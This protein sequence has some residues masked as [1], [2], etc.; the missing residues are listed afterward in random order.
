MM[1]MK[2]LVAMLL[3]VAVVP[4]LASAQSF[5]FGLRKA[6]KPDTVLLVYAGT[7]LAVPGDAPLSAQSV[8]IRNDSVAE[9]HDGYID[10]DSI[11]AGEAQVKVI[12][13]RDHFVMPGMFDAHVHLST[14]T[15]SFQI[16][17]PGINSHPAV[18]DASV[19]AL[20]N[21]RLNL[22]A[23]FTALRDLGS[24]PH[25]VFAVR[26]AINAGHFIGPTIIAS[27]AS[28]SVTAGHGDDAVSSD[29]DERARAG[30]CDG[31]DECRT[32]TRHLEKTGSDLIKFKATGGFSSNTGLLQHMS[33]EEM[34]AIVDAAHMRNIKVTVHAYDSAAI[35]DAV[36]AGVDS[37]EHGFLISDAGLK[38]MR[39]KGVVLV[40]T[41][42]VAAPPSF[43]KRFLGGREAA[44]VTM[45]N[46]ERAFER[47][48]AQSVD[49]A[50]GTDVGIYPH[51][52]NADELERMVE[53]G[54]SPA[55]ALRS[56]TVVA[57]KLFGVEGLTG[58]VAVGSRA[59][60]IAV[61]GNPLKSISVMQDVPW[62]IKSGQVVK[63]AGAMETLLDY[64][65][66]QRY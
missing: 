27:G 15:G 30:V 4:M 28:I 39:R 62:V 14:A 21:A 9:I 65:L 37:V 46:R 48:Y 55:D 36:E 63:Q 3:L 16:G 20:I 47:A 24:D 13:L 11:E 32:L 17:V 50:F 60:I 26:N 18:A 61:A 44:S 19:N 35:I 7:L 10:V 12:D 1:R 57:A 43:V 25:S 45:R 8:V 66:P 33:I 22:A 40:P 6:I 29:P 31:P 34:R 5:P 52:R 53:L 41:L 59:D 49:I 42:T 56:A 64:S 23:G 2:K 38:L 58:T 51:G 54:M